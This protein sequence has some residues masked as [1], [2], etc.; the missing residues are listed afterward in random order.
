MLQPRAH[1]PAD[2]VVTLNALDRVRPERV[3]R[4]MTYGHPIYDER[5]V[6]AQQRLPGLNTPLLAYAGAYHG[7][8][9]HEDG[10]RSGIEAARAVGM[11]WTGDRRPIP[12]RGHPRPGPPDPACFPLPQRSVAR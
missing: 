9:F 7:W 4:R 10:C 6:A 5:S 2:Y 8:G 12:L 1:G 3:L 11:E